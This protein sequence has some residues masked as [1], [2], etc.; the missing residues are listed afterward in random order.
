MTSTFSITIGFLMISYFIVALHVYNK[1]F[2]QTYKSQ[3]QI[4]FGQYSF[5]PKMRVHFRLVSLSPN[6][7]N[8]LLANRWWN[9][10]FY[11]YSFFYIKI[12][13]L[14]SQTSGWFV[15]E[16]FPLVEKTVLVVF[17]DYQFLTTKS[18]IFFFIC[19]EMVAFEYGC[20]QYDLIFDISE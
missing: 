17:P 11:R 8:C 4:T 3:F 9:T 15:I 10:W 13:H 6:S 1:L 7:T 14:F 19:L 20:F 16:Y 2:G 18:P 5:P 12:S